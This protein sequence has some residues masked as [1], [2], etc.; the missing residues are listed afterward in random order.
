MK[1]MGYMGEGPLGKGKGIFELLA[2]KF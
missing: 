2:A 1:K